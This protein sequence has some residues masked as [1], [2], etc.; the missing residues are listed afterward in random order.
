[1]MPATMADAEL[2]PCGIYRT[3]RPLGD[4]VPA[5]RLVFFHNHGDPGPGIY[6]PS[7]WAVNRA[8]W[9]EHGH[10]IPSDDWAA[11]LSP[12]L[13]EGFYRVTEEFSCCEER[14]RVYEPELLVQLGYDAEG[15]PL[16]F[17]PE[18]TEAGLAL[19]EMG[20]RLDEDRLDKLAP[21]MVA[22]ADDDPPSGTLH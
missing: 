9:D 13:D 5:G 11:S 1:M 8:A 3:T 12:L 14:C 2:P 20:L 22:E 7:G 6:L 10:T 17:V 21:L 19:P 4:D 16:L 15:H 18:W